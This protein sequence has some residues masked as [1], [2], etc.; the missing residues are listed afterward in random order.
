V[1]AL[2]FSFEEMIAKGNK[3]VQ[4]FLPSKPPI[5]AKHRQ[6]AEQGNRETT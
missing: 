4:L 1:I 6:A 5:G 3:T 2:K